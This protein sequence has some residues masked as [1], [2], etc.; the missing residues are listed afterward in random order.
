MSYRLKYSLN[1]VYRC[2]NFAQHVEQNDFSNAPIAPVGGIGGIHDWFIT[3]ETMEK[4]D[5]T[6]AY[7]FIDCD[8]K[9]AVALHFFFKIVKKDG[10]SSFSFDS[11]YRFLGPDYGVFGHEMDVSELLNEENGYLDDDGALTIEYGIHVYAIL[12][13]D[14]I[15][16][17][18]L[19]DNF[20]EYEKNEK[21]MVI[22]TQTQNWK[23]YMFYC[24]PKFLTCES[25]PSLIFEYCPPHLA[26]E[27]CLQIAHGVQI[28]LEYSYTYNSNS[29]LLKAIKVAQCLKLPNVVA[30]CERELM[31]QDICKPPVW[32]FFRESIEL[33]LRRLL[34]LFLKEIGNK[35]DLIKVVKKVGT[36]QMTG[37][38]MKMLAGK[39]FEL[40]V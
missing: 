17:F 5:K 20:F 26:I 11:S 34:R 6:F 1:G 15:W 40:G 25:S 29:I 3:L 13:D 16:K 37:E 19:K 21:N 27:T 31:K 4:N 8:E 30:Y 2:E 18:N 14:G 32:L 36:D 38:T 9:P 33:N 12:R 10:S 35:W 7:P 23:Q 24:H 22:C 39:I 28:H